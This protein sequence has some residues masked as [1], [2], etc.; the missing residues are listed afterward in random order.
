VTAAVATA[1]IIAQVWTEVFTANQTQHQLTTNIFTLLDI[2]LH[3]LGE[4]TKA[5]VLQLQIK[6]HRDVKSHINMSV[7]TLQKT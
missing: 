5:K 2:F 7:I 4:F 3:I 1:V 6:S